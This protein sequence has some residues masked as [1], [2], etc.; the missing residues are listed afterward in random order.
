MTYL[1]SIF[2]N[3][4]DNYLYKEIITLNAIY[5]ECITS[6]VE[7]IR[8][9][10][11]LQEEDTGKKESKKFSFKK[12]MDYKIEAKRSYNVAYVREKLQALSNIFMD[13]ALQR[14]FEATKYALNRNNKISKINNV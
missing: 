14:L 11:V 4:L 3:Y 8:A 5:E 7:Q 9:I 12:L 10:D 1:D 13:P 2:D 6:V